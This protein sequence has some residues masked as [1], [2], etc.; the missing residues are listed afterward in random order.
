MQTS[1]AAVRSDKAQAELRL[2]ALQAMMANMRSPPAQA[3][4]APACGAPG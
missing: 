4:R 2:Q 1:L 3:V